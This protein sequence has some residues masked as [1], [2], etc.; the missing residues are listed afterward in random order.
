MTLSISID[1]Q[2]PHGSDSLS[3]EDDSSPVHIGSHDF[4]EDY[5][6]WAQ[7]SY[8]DELKPSDSASR[9]RISHRSR[10]LHGSRSASGR[11]T[12]AHR[13]MVPERESRESYGTRSRR[14]PS[15]PESP[16]SGDSEEYP[17]PSHYTRA[18]PA[19]RRWPQAPAA[20]GQAPPYQQHPNGELVR[21]GPANPGAQP[22][23][24]GHYP[25]GAHGAQ[26]QAPHAAAMHQFY[27]HDQ[28]HPRHPSRPPPQSRMDPHNPQPHMPPHMAGHVSPSPYGASPFHQ[29]LMHYAP[30]P[31]LNYRDPYSMIPGMVPPGFFPY[32]QVPSPSQLPEAAKSPAPAPAPTPAPAPAPEPAS[33]PAPAADAA[34]DEAIARLEKLIMDERAEREAKEAARIAAIEREK[35]EK[36]AREQQ[37][38]HDRKIAEEAAFLARTDAEKRA[39]EAAAAAKD[40]A[41]KLAATAASEAA[42]AAT[43][44]ATDA[45]AAAAEQAAKEAASAAAAAANKPPPEKKKPIKFKD[46]VG[47]KFSFPFELCATWQGMEDLIKQAFLHIEVIG[48]HVAE[49]HYDLVGPN[50]DIILPQVWETVVEPDWTITMHMW[51]IPEKPKDPEPP[52]KEEG[53][54]PPAKADPPSAAAAPE[55]KKKPEV[56]KK[57]VRKGDAGGFAKWMLG[58][59]PPPKG[60]KA[61]K[62]AEK[63]PEP[64]PAPQ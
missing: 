36:A 40:E 9:P 6:E 20:P 50:G 47:R 26:F 2:D 16:D 41:E 39:A 52:A 57:P 3:D 46:A 34:K 5:D 58:G 45:A 51:P 1:P 33:A 54:A 27:P 21:L 53:A 17:I 43:K 55:P 13:R 19:E 64:A 59:R 42:A 48:P 23:G 28:G 38:A 56:V 62:A 35:A 7:L 4:D 18:P 60:P 61:A 37:L 32:P 63:K 12:P 31:F 49:G 22:Y 24:P 10:S 14:H 25:Y 11:P 8:P 15:P 29:E 44:A 30:N